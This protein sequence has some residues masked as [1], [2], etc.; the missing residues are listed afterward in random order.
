MAFRVEKTINGEKQLWLEP[1]EYQN[2]LKYAQKNNIKLLFLRYKND[3]NP[4]SKGFTIDFSW[5]K[6]LPELESL[7]FMLPLSKQSNIDSIY[8]LTK[9]KSLVYLLGEADT[10]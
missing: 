8:D 4:P 7:D 6:E 1:N 5:L 3:E 10:V 9:L 2:G